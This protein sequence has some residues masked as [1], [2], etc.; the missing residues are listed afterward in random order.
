[1]VFFERLAARAQAYLLREG[2]G[3]FGSVALFDADWG[4]LDAM[5]ERVKQ[6]RAM[7]S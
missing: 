6:A 5:G 7:A 2:V 4:A 3:Q 1:M